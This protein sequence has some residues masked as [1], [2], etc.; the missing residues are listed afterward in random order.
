[1][2][3]PGIGPHTDL[4]VFLVQARVA[5]RAPK[6]LNRLSRDSHGTRGIE[7]V[8]AGEIVIVALAP[9]C[10]SMHPENSMETIRTKILIGT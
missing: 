8:T 3:K 10:T 2:M 4:A 7:A 5:Q 1:M 6:V 9:C